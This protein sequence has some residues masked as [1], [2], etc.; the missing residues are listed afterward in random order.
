MFHFERPGE[1]RYCLLEVL[2]GEGGDRWVFVPPRQRDR[3]TRRRRRTQRE[4][5][6]PSEDACSMDA[7]FLAGIFSEALAI[8]QLRQARRVSQQFV[9]PHTSL[10][11]AGLGLANF[12]RA[13]S[14]TDILL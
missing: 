4:P 12:C 1:A 10:I 7:S 6:A 11:E 5:V 2:P 9:Q 14:R 3:H 13:R 8:S